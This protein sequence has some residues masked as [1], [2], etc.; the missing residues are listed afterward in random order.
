MASQNKFHHLLPS[1]RFRQSKKQLT[2]GTAPGTVEHIGERHMEEIKITVEDYDADHYEE[3]IIDNIENALPYLDSSTKTWIRTQ[4]LHDIEKLKSIWNFFGLHPLIQEDIVNTSQRPK[5]EIYDNCIF[6]V[7]RLLTYS[8][9]HQNI[10]TEQISIVLGSDF[11]LSFQETDTNHF[12]PVRKRMA[13]KKSRI[14]SHNVDYLAYALID[15]VVDNYFNVIENIASEIETLEEQLLE[16]PEDQ[17]LE[18]IHKKRREI[19]HIRKTVWPLRDAINSIIRDD[20]KFIEDN[21]KLYLRDVYDHTI[22]VIDTIENYRDMILGLHDMYMSYTSNK[23]N[24]VMKVL[25]VIATIFIPLTFIA[26]IYGMNFDPQVSPYN[27]PEL[28]WYWGYPASLSLMVAS[29]VVMIFYFKH[30]GWF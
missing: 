20:S 17:L 21:T 19:I 5:F 9:D 15:T 1:I 23:M 4:G 3:F 18:D 29:A 24:E 12:K 25:T 8:E 7:L 10:Q 26:G 16:E 22:Q 2:P 11:I 14:R 30:K 28:S 6:F 13:E 27:M